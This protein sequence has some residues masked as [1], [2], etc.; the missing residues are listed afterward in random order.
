MRLGRKY[1]KKEQLA[2]GLESRSLGERVDAL[3]GRPAESIDVIHT[4]DVKSADVF[5]KRLLLPIWESESR[6]IETHSSRLERSETYTGPSTL[7]GTVGYNC[8]HNCQAVDWLRAALTFGK[9]AA[10]REQASL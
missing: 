9:A 10:L 2:A 7:W 3:S 6:E 8:Y 4:S 5:S 1:Q